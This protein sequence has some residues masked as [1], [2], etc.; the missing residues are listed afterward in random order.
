M[1]IECPSLVYFG[2]FFTITYKRAIET[3]EGTHYNNLEVECSS[4]I[5]YQSGKKKGEKD[6]I[7]L[8][9]V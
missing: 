3:V 5:C 9:I 8:G 4:H 6:I 2:V 1:N 7:I